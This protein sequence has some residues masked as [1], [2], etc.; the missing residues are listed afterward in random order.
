MSITVHRR[1][2]GL[3]KR[4]RERLKVLRK[5]IIKIGVLSRSIFTFIILLINYTKT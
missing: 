3:R 5:D 2:R 4:S 1:V